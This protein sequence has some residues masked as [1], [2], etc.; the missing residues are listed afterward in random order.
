MRRLALVVGGLIVG[1]M[2]AEIMCRLVRPHWARRTAG[3]NPNTWRVEGLVTDPALDYSFEPGFTGRMTLAGNYDVPF[4]INAQGLRD[5]VEYSPLHAD[6]RRILLVGDSFVFGVGVE[7]QDTLGKQLERTLNAEGTSAHPVQ[8]VSVGAPGY[9]LDDY[10]RLIE[11]WVPKLR[12]DLVI[13]A[14]FSGNDLLDYDLKARNRTIVLDGRMLHERQAWDIRL[15]NFGAVA[16]L[17]LKRFNPY[18]RIEADRPD[19]PKPADLT[20]I[21][22]TTS[23]WI[24]HL[25][26]APGRQGPPLAI[27]LIEGR[28]VTERLSRGMPRQSPAPL[29]GVLKVARD[30]GCQV[31][32][33]ADMWSTAAA[34]L[35]QYYFPQDS[36]FSAQG[37]RLMAEW[38]APRLLEAY[39]RLVAPKP[40]AGKQ[41]PASPKTPKGPAPGPR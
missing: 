17:V 1:L 37:C 8:V 33:P 14:M 19:K 16:H 39:P 27:W 30:L 24:R 34:P 20:R 41:K 25:V 18:P 26:E 36:H 7:L 3:D 29:L 23:D 21:Y 13:I 40:P 11:R 32:D 15:R 9:G 31:F 6:Q 35:S 12:P 4:R 10:T 2:L 5:D 28:P 22:Q 38:L